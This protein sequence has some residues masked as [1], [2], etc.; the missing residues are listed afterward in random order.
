[1]LGNMDHLNNTTSLNIFM[2]YCGGSKKTRINITQLIMTL[3]SS[4]C[5]SLLTTHALTGCDYNPSFYKKGNKG[6]FK[7]LKTNVEC[8]GAVLGETHII[9][10]RDNFF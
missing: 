1:M 8:Q 9:G 6:P 3:G 10:T 5:K 4:M 2:E 7:L